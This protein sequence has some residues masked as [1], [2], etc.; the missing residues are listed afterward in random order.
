MRREMVVDSPPGMARAWQSA[1]SAGL[2][3]SKTSDD[4]P[5]PIRSRASRN[6]SMCSLTFPWSASTP[7]LASTGLEHLVF[8]ELVDI[9][10]GHRI[11]KAVADFCDRVWIIEVV[12]RFHDCLGHPFGARGLEDPRSH[13]DTVST[14]LHHHSCIRGGGD[15]TG[16]EVHDR[17][18]AALS[19]F[20]DKIRSGFDLAGIICH[21]LLVEAPQHP[22][23]AHD[24]AHVPD[25]F[26]YIASAG[27]TF[28]PDHCRAFIDPAERFAEIAG[29]ADK[30][31]LELFLIDMILLVRGGQDFTLIDHVNAEDFQHLGF[32]E[33]PDPDFAHDR[34]GDRLDDLDDLLRVGHAGDTARFPDIGR[35]ALK[36]HDCDCPGFLGDFRLFGIHYIH[37]DAPLLHGCKAALEKLSAKSQFFQFHMPILLIVAPNKKSTQQAII[38]YIRVTA[39]VAL[40]ISGPPSSSVRLP[41]PMVYTPGFSNRMPVP[42]AIADI[43]IPPLNPGR[44]RLSRCIT[45][46]AWEAVPRPANQ[47][48]SRRTVIRAGI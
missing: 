30:G 1:R 34:D 10:P 21:L 42:P 9:E 19:T 36:R 29:T 46:H 7:I 2:R 15:A 13:E 47:I 32:N 40:I 33:V 5:W 25:C 48:S 26:D 20:K 27:L 35:H 39:R 4:D 28:G 12:D 14:Q 44:L 45:C 41:S 31:D 3:T 6:A 43:T 24:C 22:D 16:R 11:A 8:P 18:P 17:Q 37:K 23:L 38:A